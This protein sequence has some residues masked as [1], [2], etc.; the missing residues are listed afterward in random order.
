MYVDDHESE[1]VYDTHFYNMADRNICLGT[2]ISQLLDAQD[3]VLVLICIEISDGL[4]V[5]KQGE[6]QENIDV[7]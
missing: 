3:C 1:R 7:P 5:V 2:N 4:V 6:S